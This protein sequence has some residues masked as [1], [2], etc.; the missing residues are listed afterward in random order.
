MTC[1]HWLSAK[2]GLVHQVNVSHLRLDSQ[3]TLS[4]AS[5]L[6]TQYRMAPT[7]EQHHKI[8]LFICWF[9]LTTLNLHVWRQ[10]HMRFPVATI[11]CHVSTRNLHNDANITKARS[12]RHTDAQVPSRLC[13]S[14]SILASESSL[15]C[16]SG[17]KADPA[18]TLSFSCCIWVSFFFKF[19]T[20]F[21]GSGA[22][23]APPFKSIFA[24]PTISHCSRQQLSKC[25]T[26]IFQGMID[27]SLRS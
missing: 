21:P 4:F 5:Y 9:E 2:H 12:L 3:L 27:P 20:R 15:A 13:S 17:S 19:L 23:S 25:N 16:C 26:S 6:Q 8:V 22:A 18:F 10:V 24:T 7:D 1:T 14:S 11:H